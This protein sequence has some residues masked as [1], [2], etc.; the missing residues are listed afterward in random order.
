ME[1][2]TTQTQPKQIIL[3][4]GAPQHILTREDSIKGGKQ[5]TPKKSLA[6]YINWMKKKGLTQENADRLKLMLCN[7][8]VSFYDTLTY[9]ES[10]KNSCTK[11]EQKALVGNLLLK[12][13][14][15]VHGTKE[16]NTAIQINNIMPISYAYEQTLRNRNSKPDNS[17]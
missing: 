10:I 4:S 11:P 13:N 17:E 12:W 9:I 7:K 15:M 1:D 5:S 2:N 3:T 14:S 8:E 16:V 6:A